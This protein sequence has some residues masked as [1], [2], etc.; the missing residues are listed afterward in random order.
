M[1]QK[2]H[3]IEGVFTVVDNE[4]YEELK[5]YIWYLG[6]FRALYCVE[7]YEWIEGKYTCIKMHRQLM[8]LK[9]GDKKGVTHL[10][11][12]GLDNRRENLAFSGRCRSKRSKQ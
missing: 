6:K 1:T 11:G 12:N 10:N 9:V 7:R 4:D 2:I 5:Q 3:L 8:G